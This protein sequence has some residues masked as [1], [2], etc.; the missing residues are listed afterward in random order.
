[1]ARTKRCVRVCVWGGGGRGCGD[2]RARAQ[3]QLEA[4]LRFETKEQAIFFCQRN[5][6]RAR[7][8]WRL[9]THTRC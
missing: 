5:G 2:A 6:A 7:M 9:R 4:H 3:I 1:M 8:R